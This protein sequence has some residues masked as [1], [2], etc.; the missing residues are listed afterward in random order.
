MRTLERAI[1]KSFEKNLWKHK[2]VTYKKEKPNL[3]NHFKN[4]IE[5]REN[6]LNSSRGK[7]KYITKIKPNSRLDL[8]IE[9]SKLSK[10]S[11]EKIKGVEKEKI[12]ILIKH[13]ETGAFFVEL[14]DKPTKGE[15]NNSKIKELLYSEG[16]TANSIED[17]IDTQIELDIKHKSEF[18]D[19]LDLSNILRFIF[20]EP[21][22]V[23]QFVLLV[24]LIPPI[25]YYSNMIISIVV[26]SVLLMY[27]YLFYKSLYYNMER[28]KYE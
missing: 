24:S 8:P 15:W 14:L 13:V 17:I 26:L 12:A 20:D 25:I 21:M 22:R 5:F 1:K 23:F 28:D 19:K 11:L 7:I 3:D 27:G 18:K 4:Q 16:I 6:I 10:D 9:I 2:S